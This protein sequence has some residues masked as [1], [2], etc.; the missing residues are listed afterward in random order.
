M[1]ENIIVSI[2]M[3]TYNHEKYI[4]K[5]LDSILKQK[6]NFPYEIVLGEDCSTD[7]TRE[8]V[9][10]YAKQ[11]PDKFKLIL[12]ETN[13]GAMYNQNEV[14]ANCTGKYIAICEGDDYWTDLNKLQKQV[15]FLEDNIDFS[16]CFTDYIIFEEN[17]KKFIF[18]ELKKK[19]NRK[20]VFSRYNLILS[21]IIPT[22]TVMF[23]NRKEVLNL[24]SVE[25]FILNY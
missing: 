23:K 18:P 6:V 4:A 12:H 8:I 3:L 9:L 21:N 25:D 15:D 14:F 20:T 24:I 22:A 2:F 17:S 1:K 7:N 5:A 13:R 11:Y 16:I 10:N 19:Y